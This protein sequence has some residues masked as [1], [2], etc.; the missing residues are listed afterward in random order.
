V[1]QYKDSIPPHGEKTET[2][3]G[4]ERDLGVGAEAR[5]EERNTDNPSLPPHDK[6]ELP[7]RREMLMRSLGWNRLSTSVRRTVHSGAESRPFVTFT[8]AAL[9]QANSR[10]IARHRDSESWV[11]RSLRESARVSRHNSIP[12]A[13]DPGKRCLE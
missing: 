3:K 7:W 4:R 5:N 13:K 6:P 12:K 8:G 9:L 11:P 10:L 2:K 1:H